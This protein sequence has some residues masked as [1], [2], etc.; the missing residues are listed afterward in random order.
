MSGYYANYSRKVHLP[1]KSSHSKKKIP[2]STISS[3]KKIP[4]STTSSPVSNVSKPATKTD[5]PKKQ[6]QQEPKQPQ[7]R[8]NGKTNASSKKRR[9]RPSLSEQLASIGA[10]ADKITNG[11]REKHGMQ[12]ATTVLFTT[13]ALLFVVGR[14]ESRSPSPVEFHQNHVSYSFQHPYQTKTRIDMIMQYSHMINASVKQDHISGNFFEFKVSTSLKHYGIDY[15]PG[16][17]DHVIKIKLAS[18]TDATRIL[19]EVLP[20]IRRK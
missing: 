18:G 12:R 20:R 11:L 8:N 6:P 13:P 19:K 1:V 15:D 7:K 14:I 10:G 2:F 5:S 3:Q 9:Q 4:F 16:K 17:R